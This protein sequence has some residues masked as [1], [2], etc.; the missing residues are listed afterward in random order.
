MIAWLAVFILVLTGHL[1]WA[2]VI[3]LLAI[4]LD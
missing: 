2:V 1:W 3:A 4:L